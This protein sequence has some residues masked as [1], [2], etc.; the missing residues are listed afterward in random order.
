MYNE[1]SPKGGQYMKRLYDLLNN[2]GLINKIPAYLRERVLS[3]EAE[4]GLIDDCRYM[5]YMNDGWLVMT[6]YTSVPV[7]SIKEAIQFIKD[8]VKQ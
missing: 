2:D 4:D 7:K 3:I 8:A 5:V 1:D 6:D